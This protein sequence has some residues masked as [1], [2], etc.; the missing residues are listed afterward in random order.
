MI[1]PW[2]ST[3][4][5]SLRPVTTSMACST[6]TTVRPSKASCV[7]WRI[8]DW[9]KAG[10][11]PAMG[12][13]SMII[14][15]SDISARATSSSLRW[16]PDSVPASSSRMW[17]RLNR[18]NSPSA[19]SVLACSWSRHLDRNGAAQSRSPDW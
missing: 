9:A 4:T 17:A 12:S 2:A 11:T 7:M 19:R 8:S 3:T 15:G 1:W 16:P 18:S 5:Q 6:N 10:F 13:S 14:T